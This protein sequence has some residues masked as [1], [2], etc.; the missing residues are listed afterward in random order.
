[1]IATFAC[2]AGA[3]A[4]GQQPASPPPAVQRR[5]F[6]NMADEDWGFLANRKYRNDFW[7]ALKYIALPKEGWYLT[8]GGEARLSPQGFRARGDDQVPSTIDNYFLQ[9]Y[10]FAADLHMGPR[11]RVFTELQSGIIKGRIGS[12]RPADQD[13]L[14]FHQAFV[15][16]K[17]PKERRRQVMIRVGRQELNIGTGRLIAPS[18]GLNVMRS[19][20]GLSAHLFSGAWSLDG[21][22]AR[23]VRIKP[24]MFDDPPDHEQ[25]FWGVSLTRQ[26]LPW[27]TSQ[28]NFYYLGLT[29]K[30]STYV[31]GIGSEDRQT[32]GSRLSGI[33]RRMDFNY[34]FI[35]QWGHFKGLPVLAYAISTDT[36]V[37]LKLGRFPA[38]LGFTLNSVSG[39]RDPHDQHLESFNPLFPGNSYSG[40]VGLL[41]PTNL[42]DFTPS[43]RVPLRRSL[44][45]AFEMPSYFRTSVRD[46]VYSIDQR[47]ILPGQSNLY[48]HVGTNPGVIVS[49]QAQRHINFTG[50]ITRFTSGKFLSDTPFKNGFGFYSIAG[51]Y[52]F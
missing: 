16:Y 18:Q 6:T 39:D 19:F 14:E 13:L 29:R 25:N 8:L 28:L 20:D 34:D 36:G 11:F 33:W 2:V 23:L 15:E 21:G 3:P 5:Y 32:V 4:W 12:P 40:M 24:G 50:V 49:W 30:K 51:T 45:V 26:R 35:A 48:R 42:S 1:M 9:R 27:K 22:A 38:R 47:L 17:S 43:L 41:G 37:K 31:Q 10:L 44:L 46:G 52:R 7:D